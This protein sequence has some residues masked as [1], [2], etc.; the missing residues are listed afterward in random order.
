MLLDCFRLALYTHFARDRVDMRIENET[1][2]INQGWRTG[3]LK[4]K[5]VQE[6]KYFIALT[7]FPRDGWPCSHPVNVCRQADL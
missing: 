7:L 5:Q 2:V 4:V 3:A 1:N 6:L